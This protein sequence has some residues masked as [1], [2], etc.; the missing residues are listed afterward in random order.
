MLITS[1]ISSTMLNEWLL[2][3]FLKLIVKYT[4]NEIGETARLQ[5]ASL[6]HWNKVHKSNLLLIFI[7]KYSTFHEILP[8]K[9]VTVYLMDLFKR[10]YIYFH[11]FNVANIIKWHNKKRLVITMK[12][13]GTIEKR[14]LSNERKMQDWKNIIYKCITATPVHSDQAY[15]GTTEGVFWKRY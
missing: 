11:Y 13:H 10:Y 9:S 5:G 14:G 12:L 3:H 4:K 2:L 6:H 15:S 7:G 8:L 1:T